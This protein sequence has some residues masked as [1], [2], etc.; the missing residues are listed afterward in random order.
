MKEIDKMSTNLHYII[1]AAQPGSFFAFYASQGDKQNAQAQ[2]S[3]KTSLSL[4]CHRWIKTEHQDDIK[5]KRCFLNLEM[6]SNALDSQSLREAVCWHFTD[7]DFLR[8]V[9]G[10]DKEYCFTRDK[11]SIE[12][13]F[14]KTAKILVKLAYSQDYMLE[15]YKDDD[16]ELI[17]HA[18]STP[19]GHEFDRDKITKHLR[20]S[21][22]CPKESCSATVSVADLQELSNAQKTIDTRIE[23]LDKALLY[24]SVPSEVNVSQDQVNEWIKDAQK[25]I[26]Q[27]QLSTANS[28]VSGIRVG[29]DIQTVEQVEA[30]GEIYK[31]LN[32]PAKAACIYLGHAQK[33]SCQDG[34]INWDD[35]KRNIEKALNL[36][37]ANSLERGYLLNLLGNICT[38]N[39]ETISAISNFRESATIFSKC[40]NNDAANSA[41]IQALKNDFS[42]EDIYEEFLERF[43]GSCYKGCILLWGAWHLVR[44]NSQIARRLGEQAKSYFQNHDSLREHLLFDFL[45]LELMLQQ[46]DS[47]EE[48]Y[49]NSLFNKLTTIAKR[50]KALGY[51]LDSLRFYE[52][53]LKFR[54]DHETYNLLFDSFYLDTKKDLGLIDKWSSITDQMRVWLDHH[55]HTG[56]W[57]E[58]SQT[59]VKARYIGL[60]SIEFQRRYKTIALEN[61]GLT[62]NPTRS[63]SFS[64][65][66]FSE[67]LADQ[68]LQEGK[69]KEAKDEYEELLL[70]Y[71]YLSLKLKD[72]YKQLYNQA[73]GDEKNEVTRAIWDLANTLIIR[74]ELLKS[75]SMV[76]LLCSLDDRLQGFSPSEKRS[77]VKLQ[78]DQLKDQPAIKS[79]AEGAYIHD[80]LVPQAHNDR[81][82]GLAPLSHRTLI[83][84]SL[85]VLK[86]W[87]LL[88]GERCVGT[89]KLSDNISAICPESTGWVVLG[90]NEGKIH[91]CHLET[92]DIETDSHLEN[93]T[94]LFGFKSPNTVQQI[95]RLGADLFA[96]FSKFS[97][98]FWERKKMQ[99]SIEILATVSSERS[100]TSMQKSGDTLLYGTDAGRIHILP[101]PSKKTE[102]LNELGFFGAERSPVVAISELSKNLLAS[103]DKNGVLD[104]WKKENNGHA[105]SRQLSRMFPDQPTLMQPLPEEHLV[106]GC[107]GYRQS[108][109]LT[110]YDNNPVT[111]FLKIKGDKKDLSAIT[112]FGSS[113]F[114]AGYGDGSMLIYSLKQ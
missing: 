55:I 57:I 6:S 4:P 1:F 62:A 43:N 17:I 7:G 74:G 32:A 19:C 29:R 65:S 108:S 31:K 37:G 41:Y 81:I 48:A 93:L 102:Q 46:N 107:M 79:Y 9:Q 42:R 18:V 68:L 106:A 30:I 58:A 2:E 99:K 8:P 103:L 34:E 15:S 39:R 26:E 111:N 71:N 112:A 96:S 33:M 36:T 54:F 75:Y 60:S 87:N 45:D 114:V 110:I 76:G 12:S 56:S 5:I 77:I 63:F 100:I 91:F 73:S 105:H 14:R 85:N 98:T 44:S 67:S 78:T 47:E 3:S 22:W 90:T 16:G 72:V 82:T 51:H 61:D 52:D 25:Y 13:V 64:A 69:L 24:F 70:T 95:V 53:A 10:S 94:P 59:A 104:L 66:E 86:V 84:T 83:S 109:Q 92:G 20:T 50:F 113:S 27:N 23:S 101:I 11:L 21:S 88:E 38:V 49:K 35:V 89:I 40:G 28:L 80:S 97:V